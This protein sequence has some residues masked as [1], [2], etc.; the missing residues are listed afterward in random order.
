[1]GVNSIEPKAI[2]STLRVEHVG[3]LLIAVRRTR[4][5]ESWGV[6][7]MGHRIELEEPGW[8]IWGRA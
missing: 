5:V 2:K 4:R 8:V 6:S 3:L 7:V 1:M